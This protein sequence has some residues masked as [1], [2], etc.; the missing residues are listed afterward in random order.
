MVHEGLL[1][2]PTKNVIKCYNSIYGC[3]NHRLHIYFRP[4]MGGSMSVSVKLTIG[5]GPTAHLVALCNISSNQP[6][7]TKNLWLFRS[8]LWLVRLF[9]G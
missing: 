8:Q 9:R 4:F 7:P 1:E 5:S 3:Y 6:D 2:S